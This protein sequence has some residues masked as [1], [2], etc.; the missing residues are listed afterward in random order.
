MKNNIKTPPSKSNAIN[1]NNIPLVPLTDKQM[2]SNAI[3]A[4]RN[5]LDLQT[6]PTLSK[7]NIQ[8]T[9]LEILSDFGLRPKIAIND[10]DKST[11]R[12]S[13]TPH[14]QTPIDK[15]LY[16]KR[17]LNTAHP[18]SKTLS[19]IKAARLKQSPY[20]S[21][22]IPIP[23]IASAFNSEKD[24]EYNSDEFTDAQLFPGYVFAK[25]DEDNFQEE[26]NPT[27]PIVN[28]KTVPVEFETDGPKSGL[29]FKSQILKMEEI[30]KETLNP[31]FSKRNHPE[32]ILTAE[33]K[34]AEY[35]PPTYEERILKK[36]THGGYLTTF[37]GNEESK[38]FKEQLLFKNVVKDLFLRLET[39]RSNIAE[40]KSLLVNKNEQFRVSKLNLD[41]IIKELTEFII[42]EGLQNVFEIE[43]RDR[44]GFV[45]NTSGIV[46]SQDH[47]SFE[48]DG[49]QR[50]LQQLVDG[51]YFKTDLPMNARLMNQKR[52]RELIEHYELNSQLISM[53]LKDMSNFNSELSQKRASLQELESTEFSLKDEIHKMEDEDRIIYRELNVV[54]KHRALQFIKK[55]SLI[56]PVTPQ[57]Q[58]NMIKKTYRPDPEIEKKMKQFLKESQ[59]RNIFAKKESKVEQAEIITKPKLKKEDIDKIEYSTVFLKNDKLEK[60]KDRKMDII[61]LVL[62]QEYPIKKPLDSKDDKIVPNYRKSMPK[63]GTIESRKASAINPKELLNESINHIQNKYEETEVKVVE[64]KIPLVRLKNITQND[65][66][67][68]KFTFEPPIVIFNDIC[69]DT[70]NTIQVKV[71]NTTGIVNSFKLCQIPARIEENLS[72][73]HFSG[74]K[75][76]PGEHVI[77]KLIFKGTKDFLENKLLGFTS[78]L[79]FSCQYGA[80]FSLPTRYILIDKILCR[81]YNSYCSIF[82]WP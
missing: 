34:V 39:T 21:A 74:G 36:Y 32:L 23:K 61:K 53:C 33:N 28:I 66:W 82:D 46:G 50:D 17:S 75:I 77:I 3:L 69:S 12:P 8:K 44:L 79:L 35:P 38:K 6:N 54:A 78:N 14:V 51:K 80:D 27:K 9:N 1:T 29:I 49:R 40:L 2:K 45:I 59:Q 60:I 67:R 76:P 15:S 41:K 63:L 22:K 81:L 18:N 20:P 72:V 57:K 52:Y 56:Q 65:D 64:R 42:K 37:K 30:D 26:P 71:I 48:V 19:E 24:D 58:K 5:A 55:Q 68:P 47:E 73:N 43:K 25:P 16:K 70:E 7:I 31:G 62:D 11:I 10:I 13:S 4:S